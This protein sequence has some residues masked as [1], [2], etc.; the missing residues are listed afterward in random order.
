MIAQAAGGP[1]SVTGDADRPP[2]KPGPSFGDTGTGMLMAI[3]ILGRPASARP[4]RQGPAATGGDA[5]RDDPLYAGAVLAHPAERQ[6]PTARRQQPVEPG[7]LVP[8]ALYPCKPGGPNDYVYVFTS[9]A[10]PEHWTR[11]LKAIGREDLTGDPRYDTR[12][13]RSARAAEVDE[14]IAA[15]TRE[16]TKEEAM[17]L[18]GASRRAGRRRIRHARIAE[19]SLA[20]R[21]RHHAEDRAPDHR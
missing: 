3:S 19:R 6:G 12:P 1:I 18:I 13:A 11:L 16:H 21:A 2:V 8:S 20:R 17:K 14:I 5:G 15:W 10:N 7:G 4:H 9:R